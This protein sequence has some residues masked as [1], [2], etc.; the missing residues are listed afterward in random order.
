MIRNKWLTDKNILVLI[1]LIASCLRFYKI[2]FQSFWLDE[3]HTAIEADPALSWGELFGYL[4]C[5][6][7][8]PPLFLAIEKILFLIFGNT[9]LVARSFSGIAGV[10]GVWA[11]YLLGKE[12]YSSKLGLIA[13]TLC[14][15]NYFHINYSQEARPY[16]L[17]FLFAC[18]SFYQLARLIKN[19]S[20]RNSLFY[21]LW[22]ILMIYTHYFGLFTLISQIAIFIFFTFN[23]GK[24]L[25]LYLKHSIISGL[26]I[27]ISY[28]PW[29]S[30]LVSMTA[31][32]KFWIAPVSQTFAID[33]FY[34][35][36]GNSDLLKPF[37]L[38]F[39]IMGVIHLL[40]Y[41]VP[42]NPDTKTHPL[43]FSF[44]I[45]FLWISITYLIP[46]IRS[47]MVV[48]MLFPRYAIV[49]LP[50][51]LFI[52]SVGVESISPRI[53]KMLLLCAFCFLSFFDFAINKKYYTQVH[54]TQFREM[55]A[56]I[57]SEKNFSYPVLSDATAWHQQYYLKKMA[58]TSPILSGNLN[59][60]LDSILKKNNSQS[61]NK[62]F[63]LTGAHGTAK[64]DPGILKQLDSS[65]IL[66]KQQNFYDA[67]ALLYVPRNAMN[68][69][70]LTMDYHSFSTEKPFNFNGDTVVPI[71]EREIRSDTFSF[72]KGRYSIQIQIA[73]T[74]AL[75]EYPHIQVFVN[76]QLVDKFYVTET[77]KFYNLSFNNIMDS[78]ATIRIIMDNDASLKSKGE[79][80][81][82][83]L[84]S[85][86]ILENGSN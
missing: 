62:G 3:L 34:E 69:N 29:I 49:V 31:I 26:L 70:S 9:E 36:F 65:F 82:A 86:I 39:L 22:T 7:Q 6:D 25:K 32:K 56:F 61:T 38:L 23:Q 16:A 45:C 42:A 57:A 77:L 52:L 81:N 30:Y 58:Y 60:Q 5:C 17:V 12:L 84:K 78:H 46:Y 41:K 28:I 33:F 21:S 1:L 68:K 24:N 59:D 64:P 55:A 67:W 73:G 4:R 79:D 40:L 13:A 66:F 44:T 74:S 50:A 76:E 43:H 20:W 19:P 35:F 18:M 37:L 27:F 71:W 80:R 75:N 54:K 11:I 53:P 8:H 47:V 10:T 51:F 63:W 48:P 83:F 85:I 14:S 72:K 15:F 2:N